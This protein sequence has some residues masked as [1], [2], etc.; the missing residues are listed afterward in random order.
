MKTSPLAIL[1]L[2]DQPFD[3]EL[4]MEQLKA[5]DDYSCNITWAKDQ[6]TF[7][8]ALDSQCPDV[9]L[10]DYSLLGFN[11]L[12]ALKIV[13]ERKMLV[14][15]IFVTGALDEET[16]VNTI[17]AG[18][19]DY[20]VK[21]RL[22][23][24]PLAI[25]GALQ[26]REERLNV[27]K[28]ELE[29]RKLLKAIEQSPV[30]IVVMNVN[31]E[32]EYVN[33]RFTEDTG[34][35]LDDLKESNSWK[36]IV[37][38]LPEK[39]F[40]LLK[41]QSDSPA[42]W[43]GEME[44]KKKNGVAYWESVSVS[45]LINDI[46]EITH[47]IIFKEDITPRKRMVQELIKARNKAER[48]DKLKDAFLQ[49]MSHEI[50][51]PLN[52]IV[53]FSSLLN[54][55]GGFPESLKEYTSIIL[56]SSNQLLSIVN[57]ILTISRIQTGQEIITVSEVLI[58]SVIDD[59]Y[60]IFKSQAQQNNINFTVTRDNNDRNLV[61]LTDETKLVQILTNLLNNAFKY[62]HEGSITFGYT[63][64]KDKIGF[65]VTDTG[66]GIAPEN[67][68][69]IFDRFRQ[70][71]TSFA[72]TYGG[73]GLGLSISKSFAE[74]LHGNIWVESSLGKGS[75]FHLLLPCQF[76]HHEV[77]APE[78]ASSATF[79]REISILVAEDEKN[80]YQL[81]KT[82]LNDACITLHH[83]FNGKEAVDFC[84]NHK[85]VDLVLMDIKMPEMDGI[86]AMLEIRK[87]LDVPFIAQTA[88]ALESERQQLLKIGFNDYISK[89]I[90]KETLIEKV[91]KWTSREP[92]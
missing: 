68:K 8:A 34:Y 80:N 10:S 51:T 69:I 58:N 89:P 6:D 74:L 16:A 54:D 2:E 62:T 29:S 90:R 24:L 86:T 72:R 45:P 12:E 27:L 15:F 55:A 39:Y 66:I 91:I 37:E 84:R 31:H 9:I 65:F 5:L 63:L 56:S 43:R 78:A 60:T 18:A 82:Y 92:E 47:Y 25:K 30:H 41:L 28:A 14:P 20:V 75:S 76:D 42:N 52:A 13:N 79:N 49:N 32:I 44:S 83:A 3:A 71:D 40:R 70:A 81:I 1:L 46:N 88:Y 67:H 36:L 61:I 48:S 11:G 35:T 57:D 17:K 53:G 33:K 19:W 59:L 26:L 85:S 23:R 77:V 4:I 87:L 38:E 64:K 21:D 22:V 50:R 7:I 73:T